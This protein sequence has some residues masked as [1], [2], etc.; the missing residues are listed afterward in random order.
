M[1]KAGQVAT[2]AGRMQ[3][4]EDLL[5]PSLML[6]NLK[7]LRTMAESTG[8]IPPIYSLQRMPNNEEVV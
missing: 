3:N 1:K 5:Q 8:A 7:Y 6:E 4:K 2:G